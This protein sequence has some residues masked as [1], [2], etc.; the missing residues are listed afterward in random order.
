[1]TQY[2]EQT[3]FTYI[4]LFCLYQSGNYKS[5]AAYFE[6]KADLF[7]MGQEMWFGFVEMGLLVILGHS[8]YQKAIKWYQKARK[9]RSFHDLPVLDKERWW[10]YGA[11]LEFL[12]EGTY[13]LRGFRET[14]FLANDPIYPTQKEGYNFAYL[15][16]QILFLYRK[17]EV[18]EIRYKT[19][20]LRDLLENTDNKK[21]LFRLRH[22]I[23]LLEIAADCDF[24]YGE[25]VW[26]GES[27]RRRLEAA[28][29]LKAFDNYMEVIRFENVWEILLDRMKNH[30]YFQHY[31]FYH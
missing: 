27:T 6:E 9:L 23:R 12:S 10:L 25:T 16:L 31:R 2:N 30:K 5:G 1:M 29:A 8:D 13:H 19:D 3:H 28:P 26:K 24:A 11:Y 4:K 14:E 21:D 7:P 22:F 17:G 20:Q 18:S 15:I